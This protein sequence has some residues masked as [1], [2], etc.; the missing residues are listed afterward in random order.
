MTVISCVSVAGH[1]ISPIMGNIHLILKL[2]SYHS[3]NKTKTKQAKQRRQK[4]TTKSIKKEQ[5]HSL[6]QL[7]TTSAEKKVYVQFA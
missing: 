2:L 6:D 7:T 3:K 5:Q 4:V 1:A